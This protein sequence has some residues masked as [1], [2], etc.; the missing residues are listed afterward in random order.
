MPSQIPEDG[1][2]RG[3]LWTGHPDGNG[4]CA[5]RQRMDVLVT[6]EGRHQEARG[7]GC[8]ERSNYNAVPIVPTDALHRILDAR[9]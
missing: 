9:C 4:D 7:E 2:D 3:K 6:Q 8:C 1:G 5:E